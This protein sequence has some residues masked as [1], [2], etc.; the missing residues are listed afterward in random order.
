M[1]RNTHGDRQLRVFVAVFYT[2]D[3]GIVR[4]LNERGHTLDGNRMT[5]GKLS[6]P[7]W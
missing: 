7:F 6:P 1:N 2:P 3:Y 4:L 5:S